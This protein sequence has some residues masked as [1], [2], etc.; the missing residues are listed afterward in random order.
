MK[1]TLD[2]R[3]IPTLALIAA[4]GLGLAGA[5]RAQEP[6]E[7]RDDALDSLLEKLGGEES[8]E[9]RKADA[10]GDDPAPADKP[11]AKADEPEGPAAKAD[12]PAD[13]SAQDQAVDDLLEKLGATKDEPTAEDRPRQPGGGEKPPGEPDRPEIGRAH[14]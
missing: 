12:K 14:V 5:A 1:T 2:R 6:A 11:A 3:R 7:P 10:G 8:K 4:L 9:K 13:V